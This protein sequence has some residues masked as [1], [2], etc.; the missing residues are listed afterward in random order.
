MR[1]LSFLAA[2]AALTLGSLSPAFAGSA[3]ASGAEAALSAF[4][5][6]ERR[7]ARRPPARPRITVRPVRPAT[8]PRDRDLS[9]YRRLCEPVFEERWIPQWGGNV[10]YTG[11]R[12][13]WVL[14]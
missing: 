7:A 9:R 8:L 6:Q 4:S 3:T 10:L 12:C 1:G 5:A 11:E 14:L 13:R 2:A